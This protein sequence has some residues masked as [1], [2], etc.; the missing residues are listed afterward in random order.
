MLAL[1]SLIQWAGLLLIQCA[2]QHKTSTDREEELLEAL[3]RL[4][5]LRSVCVTAEIACVFQ[6]RVAQAQLQIGA[7]PSSST[8]AS[9]DP[10]AASSEAVEQRTLF[11]QAW[12][13]AGARQLLPEP[14]ES[15]PSSPIDGHLIR[16]ETRGT[17]VRSSAEASSGIVDG[18]SLRDRKQHAS[19][20]PWTYS[21]TLGGQYVYSTRTDE[22]IMRTGEKFSRPAHLP[23][24]RL[25]SSSWDGPLPFRY[26]HPVRAKQ[27]SGGG[28]PDR[29]PAHPRALPCKDD[30]TES[31]KRLPGDE[32]PGNAKQPRD[33]WVFQ[34]D[35]ELQVWFNAWDRSKATRKEPL[36][37]TDM[38]SR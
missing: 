16:P 37:E 35:G 10:H 15:L 3:R 24:D 5:N 34:R 21:S 28:I 4:K 2:L 26:R 14:S 38:N 19:V 30:S 6:V 7:S 29:T 20:P 32:V 9:I 13:R 27:S 1:L 22:I 31:P 36:G 25:Q 17:D 11:E 12:N 18:D 8:T 33:P 23:V